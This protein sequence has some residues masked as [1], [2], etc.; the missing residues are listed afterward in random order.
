MC[1]TS[2]LIGFCKKTEI[3]RNTSCY[4]YFKW[5]AT[6][7]RSACYVDNCTHSFLNRLHSFPHW[8]FSLTVCVGMIEEKSMYET[9]EGGDEGIKT[10]RLRRKAQSRSWSHDGFISVCITKPEFETVQWGRGRPASKPA[11]RDNFNRILK[12]S[13]SRSWQ[14]VGLK[15]PPGVGGRE[16]VHVSGFIVRCV[17]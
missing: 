13:S 11:M 14:G 2:G 6:S 4:M 17:P 5:H 15:A 16:L 9:Q 3:M 12:G 10:G 8:I 7:E 1:L